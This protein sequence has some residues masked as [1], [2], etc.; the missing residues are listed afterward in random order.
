MFSSSRFLVFVL[1]VKLDV[2]RCH[3]NDKWLEKD[4]YKSWLQKD[5]KNPN[6]AF[7]FACGKFL[8]KE[9]FEI[10]K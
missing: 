2:T 1:R 9:I 7:Y 8:L 6:K 3:F 4:G 5:D 10:S